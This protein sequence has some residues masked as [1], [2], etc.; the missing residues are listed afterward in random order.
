MT[1]GVA[2][3]VV[4]LLA[5]LTAFTGRQGV[6]DPALRA[7]VDRFFAAQQAED[8]SAYLALW[9]AT[10]RPPTA[11]QLKYIFEAGDDQFSEIAIV[12]TYPASENLRVRVRVTR[13]RTTPSR[14]P[15]R[16]PF[17]FHSTMSWSLVYVREGG[18]WKL[19]REGPAVDALADSLMAA[20]IM[21]E[22][23]ALL[24]AEP[25]LVTVELLLALSRRAGQAAQEQK[26]PQAQ[27]GFERMREVE[28]QEE[29]QEG[30]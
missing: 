5:S 9:S 8:V 7:A 12:G 28:K 2:R 16:P 30:P 10:V 23:E 18:D 14:V 29:E 1:F 27:L 11:E 13:D 17:T 25:D 19:V 6:D 3:T 21:E 20:A 24:Q 4:L 26:Y 15:G 22:R